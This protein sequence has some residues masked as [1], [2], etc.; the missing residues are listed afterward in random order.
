[1]LDGKRS[2]RKLCWQLLSE[3]DRILSSINWKSNWR[4]LCLLEAFGLVLA[5]AVSGSN[6]WFQFFPCEC[7]LEEF[8]C[9]ECIG[10]SFFAHS[11]T[12]N[13]FFVCSPQT[14]RLMGF[15]LI[16][17]GVEWSGLLQITV[18]LRLIGLW[19]SIQPLIWAGLVLC[20]DKK[21]GIHKKAD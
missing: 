1:M 10:V 7:S 5:F 18:R 11:L 19:F 16:S 3:T 2:R 14:K 12:T 17:D 6:M 20:V 21:Y 4:S 15:P 9:E 8:L 13:S